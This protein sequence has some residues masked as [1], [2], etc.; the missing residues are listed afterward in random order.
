MP[1]F[2]AVPRFVS[3][4]SNVSEDGKVAA[5]ADFWELYPTATVHQSWLTM[6]DELV[7]KL[8]FTVF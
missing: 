6:Y 8:F 5:D 7:T 2:N 1:H 3:F 4:V